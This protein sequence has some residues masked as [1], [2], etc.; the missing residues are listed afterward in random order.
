M[1]V[2][3]KI[4]SLLTEKGRLP[5][6][7]A[8]T[9]SNLE[10]EQ[11]SNIKKIVLRTGT[12]K[13]EFFQQRLGK[14]RNHEG[15]PI[16]NEVRES[17]WNEDSHGDTYMIPGMRATLKSAVELKNSPGE[18]VDGELHLSGDV[19]TRHGDVLLSK[20]KP[21]SSP[22]DVARDIAGMLATGES[23][24]NVRSSMAGLLKDAN[25]G[26]MLTES[27]QFKVDK[28]TLDEISEYVLSLTPQQLQRAPAGIL[29]PHPL[30]ISRIKEI[31]G[32]MR[33]EEG[34]EQKTISLFNSLLNI[35]D[36]LDV[37]LRYLDNVDVMKPLNSNG[38][39][40]KYLD[41]SAEKSLIS[42]DEV[43]VG[44]WSEI[45][46][47]S[48]GEIM[49][50]ESASD[51]DFEPISRLAENNFRNAPNYSYLQGADNEV[52]LAKFIEANSPSNVKQLCE[53]PQQLCNLVAKINDE[54]VGYRV[55]RKR[56]DEEK[57][58]I[59]ADGRRMHVALGKDG[60][61]L[62][63]ILLKRSEQIAKQQGC[64]V[65]EIHATGTS[66]EWFIRQ[67]YTLKSQVENGRGVFKDKP[68]VFFLMTKDMEKVV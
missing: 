42:N 52:E 28:F 50:L 51:D 18:T 27:H 22:E 19:E 48:N 7:I 1:E 46:P 31:D 61:G 14:F 63:T 65:M 20:A 57:Q 40:H 10:V 45:F 37:L 11:L 21:G 23:V 30:I 54:V 29:W 64:Q 62:G 26:A 47:L 60:M 43:M 38:N 55:V 66:H 59:I 12:R 24:F 25:R 4:F 49:S 15:E 9:P 6:F 39:L 56:V 53:T 17:V 8:L 35:P 58:L 5:E 3:P 34:F 68:S 2:K 44:N 41:S 32:V 67:G 16:P 33:G 36:N 13:A